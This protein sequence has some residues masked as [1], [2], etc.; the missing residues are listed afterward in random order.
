MIEAK[1]KGIWRITETDSWEEDA[2]DL[3][4]PAHIAFDGRSGSFAMIAMHANLDCRYDG[5]R[6]EFSFVGDDEGTL[7]VGRGWAELADASTIEGMLDFHD[8][9]ETAFTAER[10]R[11]VKKPAVRRVGKKRRK[12]G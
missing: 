1:F 4:E 3:V 10:Q 8:G 12:K 9:D 2:L 6:V 11:K 7:L 5:N